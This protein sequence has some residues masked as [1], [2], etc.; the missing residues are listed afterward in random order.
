MAGIYLKS[1]FRSLQK[2]KTNTIIAVI[3]LS[4]G[5]AS[6]IIIGLF[7][8]YELDWDKFNTNYKRI[9]R[10]QTYKTVNDERFMQSTPAVYEFIKSKY[11]GI[12]NQAVV[13]PSQEE[14][15]SVSE[16]DPTVKGKGQYADQGF[17][18]IFSY[19][20]IYGKKENAL[21]DPFS[22]ILSKSLAKTLFRNENPVGSSLL[23]DK[24]H[25]LNVTGVYEDLPKNAH[26]RPDYIISIVSL[27][28]LWYSNP[29]ENWQQ[30]GF[31]NYI[32]VREGADIQ[33]IDDEIK[34]MLKDKV[35]TDYR[36]LYLRP[37]SAL[38]MYSTNN[39]YTIILYLLGI[40]AVFVLILASINFMNISIASSTLRAKEIGIKKVIGSS[41]NQLI[42]QIFIESTITTML[43]LFISLIFVELSIGLFNDT[44][45]KTMSL[46]NLFQDGFYLLIL[47]IIL[48]VSILS[49]IYPSWLITSVS[50]LE[51]FKKNLFK[52]KKDRINLKKYLVMFQFAISIGLITLA[53][54]FSRQIRYMHTKELGY[55]KDNLLF[56]EMTPSGD[57]VNFN[58]IRNR[59]A[60][61]PEIKSMS[62]SRGFP[63]NSSKYT[64]YLMLN[65]EGRS[66]EELIDVT[67]FWVSYDFVKTLE[68]D[69]LKGRGFSNEITSDQGNSCLINETAA[70]QFG[71]DDPIGKFIN[72]RKWEVVGVFKDIHFEDMYNQI[73]PLVLTLKK[74]D[75]PINGHV[76]IGFRI[77]SDYT[78]ELKAK[79]EHVIQENFPNDPFELEL[80]SDHFNNDQ[81][82]TVFDMIDRI[83]VFLSLVAI[84][85]S[86]FGVIGLVNHSL[87]QR[88]KEI[89]IRKV[90]GCSSFTIFRSLTLE[91]IA[92]ILAAS[93]F[94]TFTAR[95]IFSVLPLNYPIQQHITDYLIGIFMA[96]IVTLV[97]IFYK[98]LKES[99]RNPV[100]SL[101]YE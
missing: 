60:N 4:V 36:Q 38:Y 20:M 87:N 99:T 80:F 45:D 82:F 41:R 3:G 19:T 26:L 55:T 84:V 1:A 56:L 63:I 96:L 92:L 70:K 6:F 62:F 90:N 17:I 51:L 59:F 25:L 46:S 8:K 12:E 93:V 18:D 78:K 100:E 13:F 57:E 22:I 2:R 39:N 68:L 89:A 47:S 24:K 53:I 21:N 58:M 11:Q 74:D 67:S 50:S 75:T 27:K 40:F 65:S 44:L 7:I 98:T 85:L 86:V 14:Y 33:K 81:I 30:S 54:L 77:E 23:L 91:Y 79:I 52:G 32:L 5:F 83:I 71:W 66:R 28:T 69:I 43:A 49:S 101:R 88:T 48:T 95:Y 9:Y 94:G 64:S 37:L 16:S 29:F 76:Y 35:T 72:D 15:L 10:I 73:R 61:I 31:Y 34:D 42:L 97:A